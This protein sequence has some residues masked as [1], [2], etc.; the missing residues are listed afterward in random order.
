M[1]NIKLSVFVATC[2]ISTSVSAYNMEFKEGWNLVS[3][4]QKQNGTTN[5]KLD[6][7]KNSLGDAYNSIYS[8]SNKNNILSKDTSKGIN[9]SGLDLNKGFWIKTTKD[10][11]VTMIDGESEPLKINAGW[12]LI[13]YNKNQ[14]F[15]D[16]KSAIEENGYKYE[17]IYSF[18]NSNGVL[19]KLTSKGI[20]NSGITIGQGYWLK[21][22]K[23]LDK[24]A[25]GTTGFNLIAYTDK[26]LVS[27]G[28]TKDVSLMID[29]QNV[30][31][32]IPTDAT[33]LT[34]RI[35]NPYGVEVYDNVVSD[36]SS[37]ATLTGVSL[38]VT[39]GESP[40]GLNTAFYVVAA[41]A[42]GVPFPLIGAEVYTMSDSGEQKLIGTTDGEGRFVA[43]GLTEGTKLYFDMS[44]YGGSI[45]TY[46]GKTAVDYVTL[47]TS[48]EKTL[49]GGYSNDTDITN[50][51]MAR[52]L[53]DKYSENL[54]IDGQTV[55]TLYLN[56]FSPSSNVSGVR[57]NWSAIS[58]FSSFDGYSVPVD[59]AGN[60][61]AGKINEGDTTTVRKVVSAISLQ[62]YKGTNSKSRFVGNDTLFSNLDGDG[63]V[64][65]YVYL[66]NF[67]N[68]INPAELMASGAPITLYAFDGKSWTQ[69]AGADITLNP[70]AFK[71]DTTNNT[72]SKA[73]KAL[74]K[75]IK[76]AK[77]YIR[78]K[79]LKGIQTLV[80][81]TSYKESNLNTYK[82]A[83]KV[84]E[85]DGTP[86]PN[87]KVVV[88][89]SLYLTN[90]DGMA[91]VDFSL[92]KATSNIPVSV[93]APNHYS[94]GEVISTKDVVASGYEYTTTLQTP[95]Q[96][97]KIYVSVQDEKSN[98]VAYSDVNI[99]TPAVLSDIKLEDGGIEVGAE[100]GAKYEWYVKAHDA[101]NSPLKKAIQLLQNS[102]I[103]AK[104]GVDSWES[105]TTNTTNKVTYKE[106]YDKIIKSDGFVSGQ[107]DIGV[108]VIHDNGLVDQITKTDG[109]YPVHISTL[110]LKFNKELLTSNGG[111]AFFD[112]MSIHED[113]DLESTLL[114]DVGSQYFDATTASAKDGT[115]HVEWYGVLKYANES[116]SLGNSYYY[117]VNDKQWKVET[118]L[119]DSISLNT[120][121]TA[122]AGVLKNLVNT[123]NSPYLILENRYI[124]F[125]SIVEYMTNSDIIKALFQTRKDIGADATDEKTIATDGL[126]VYLIP[127]I[128]Y[129]H[130]AS[131]NN[132]SN[133]EFGA[134]SWDS[135]VLKTDG[136]IAMDYQ[137]HP[138]S[139][140]PHNIKMKTSSTGDLAV[141]NIPLEFGGADNSPDS[142]L[143][144]K[145]SKDGYLASNMKTVP[146]FSMDNTATS[147]LE[148]VANVSM[149]VTQRATSTLTTTVKDTNGSLIQNAVVTI[150]AG[151]IQEDKYQD[152]FATTDST[153]S[154]SP[155]VFVGEYL[156]SVNAD[157][158]NAK[159]TQVVVK[160]G[161][162]T[163]EIKMDKV[164]EGV[165]ITRPIF[166]S[167]DISVSG[168]KLLVQ[169][170]IF[171]TDTGFA[172][173][174]TLLAIVNDE[175]ISIALDE[176]NGEFVSQLQLIQ[177][178]NTV[179]FV[180]SNSLG[181]FTTKEY[182][183]DYIGE[184]YTL[185]GS[186]KTG[187]TAQSGAI[188]K[189]VDEAGEE[190]Y[191]IT[192]TL[193]NYVADSIPASGSF[194]VQAI[195]FKADGSVAVSEIKDVSGESFKDGM[196]TV[197]LVL[198]TT[199]STTTFDSPAIVVVDKIDGNE[200]TDYS[201][202]NSYAEVSG[203]LE[204]FAGIDAG[205]SAYAEVT[206]ATG[207][208]QTVKIRPNSSGDGVY[209]YKVSIPLSVGS[210][211]I[212]IIA[213]NPATAKMPKGSI[214]T[215][216]VF[217]ERTE[218]VSTATK[219]DG[220]LLLTDLFGKSI[221]NATVTAKTLTGDLITIVNSFEVNASTYNN[222]PVTASVATIAG[223]LPV[224]KFINF[225]V[226]ADGYEKNVK[227]YK[228]ESANNNFWFVMQNSK[229]VADE[230]EIEAPVVVNTAPVIE[231]LVAYPTLI[232]Q[233]DNLYIESTVYDA[234]DDTLTTSWLI[235]GSVLTSEKYQSFIYPVATDMSTGEHNLT[236]N[237]SDGNLSDSKT[238]SF[239]VEAM[240]SAVTPSMSISS[241]DGNVSITEST[242]TINYNATDVDSIQVISTNTNVATVAS[243]TTSASSI[244]VTLLGVVGTT[245]IIFTPYKENVAGQTQVFHINVYD[246]DN[247][248]I[249]T[250]PT[251]PNIEDNTTL[252]LSTPPSVPSIPN[253]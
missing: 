165:T 117:D 119:N 136:M 59:T 105:L 74:L 226:T 101:L 234:E 49:D 124:T 154:A 251:V 190:Y 1:K 67:A 169:G 203:R 155:K 204:D 104:V 57:L 174:T 199:T 86:I 28:T 17:S 206:N 133:W 122:T 33:K 186:V 75:N 7:L 236:M 225:E 118:T 123:P 132:V 21:I 5:I 214:T 217:I 50:P 30:T 72:D 141:T 172:N 15:N 200:F 221:E 239:T 42:S 54:K 248:G 90:K 120:H 148:D 230:T 80:A 38:D 19:S 247:G 227:T 2:L 212:S 8:F 41:T 196:T 224:G 237:V 44:G 143:K 29:D 244:E 176:T 181:K 207:T 6:V 238:I 253:S 102:R 150:P 31:L 24:Q 135:D 144:V 201:T 100:V 60:K 20:G 45:V 168:D 222:L 51:S 231:E 208:I 145:A 23:S 84:V 76:D 205:A 26:D 171:D 18:A 62:A 25:I 111:N 91:S 68:G 96:S 202:A 69:V 192:D 240:A 40:I 70:I 55:G 52:I 9:T 170:Q 249:E 130:E 211:S 157:G 209:S 166:D 161:V 175:A 11:N 177:G 178:V 229:I 39:G 188:I 14:S 210:N 126:S 223:K 27:G 48:E 164:K 160:E 243:E 4:P 153:G 179:E 73:D 121:D 191:F 37:G 183:I 216:P 215:Y 185:K 88:A 129:T 245:D 71:D 156:V 107:V 187:D 32:K 77:Y 22:I 151:T 180:A 61:I 213:T 134:L 193:G 47:N 109:N 152:V 189:V 128:T 252:D 149:G 53:F 220:I 83:V 95:P 99:I 36:F 56:K 93:S 89:G 92:P 10:I 127:H 66:T 242:F 233:G 87:A 173:A 159:S 158:Y 198:P 113:Y 115:M 197:D 194:S 131:D 139:I 12:S 162:N 58:D 103:L 98:G 82:F 250:P 34:V 35:E 85:A 138:A 63:V 137:A 167:F 146:K 110:D 43:T 114:G 246:P 163:L 112:A 142:Y 184:L 106:L 218:V 241:T 228:I 81:V 232:T 79:N 235:D 195:L 3:F 125:D 16:F 13:G 64:E 108:R 147:V 219:A 116:D 140:L 78:I 182:Y 46:T 97:A 94:F 65:S